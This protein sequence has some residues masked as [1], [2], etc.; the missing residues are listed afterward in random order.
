MKCKVCENELLLNLDFH[1][2]ARDE[3]IER[4]GLLGIAGKSE[5]ESKLYDAFDCPFCGCQN[6]VG[7][8]KRDFVPY[9]PGVIEELEE[10]EHE[11][12]LDFIATAISAGNHI[13][14][15]KED[16]ESEKSE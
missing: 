10:D 8:R 13:K 11:D 15:E 6:I 14:R 3:E 2:I 4:T 5:K 9:V 7:D 1:Y 16:E 12:K